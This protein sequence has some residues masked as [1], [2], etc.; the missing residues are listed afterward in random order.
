MFAH[1][2]KL[3][4]GRRGA[5]AVCSLQIPCR[6]RSETVPCVD[7]VPPQT[8]RGAETGKVSTR[9]TPRF[10]V[11][12]SSRFSRGGGY[13]FAPESTPRPP[14]AVRYRRPPPTRPRAP[15]STTQPRVPIFHGPMRHRR[16]SPT[17]DLCLPPPTCARAAARAAVDPLTAKGSRL[18][19]EHLHRQPSL[20]CVGNWA[21]SA[22]GAERLQPPLGSERE[23]TS[24]TLRWRRCPSRIQPPR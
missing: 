19:P 16:P 1:F 3:I 18:G 11:L 6:R 9:S 7:K 12:F 10:G 13:R 14:R 5:S 8:W 4:P 22:L 2:I 23:D 24:A 21:N 20:P 17:C 15:A